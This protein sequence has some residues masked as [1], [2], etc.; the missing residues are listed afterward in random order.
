MINPLIIYKPNCFRFSNEV[1]LLK[2]GWNGKP[3]VIVIYG[4]VDVEH[5]K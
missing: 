3:D 2:S 1:I 4:G 5:P